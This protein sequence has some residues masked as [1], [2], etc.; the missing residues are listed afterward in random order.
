MIDTATLTSNT[1]LASSKKGA[2]DI[3]EVKI[4]SIDVK[5][6][7]DWVK[8]ILKRIEADDWTPR[9]EYLKCRF[10]PYNQI[11]LDSKS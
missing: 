4:S 3:F 1:T 10:C 6:Y 9:P 11:C 8:G 2:I 7:F 5:A